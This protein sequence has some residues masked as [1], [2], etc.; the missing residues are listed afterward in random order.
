MKSH[1]LL[2]LGLLVP[3]AADSLAGTLRVRPDGSGDVPT[4]QAAVNAAGSG[5]DVL[6][7]P[8]TYT[9]PGN[10]Y[11]ILQ[12][13]GVTILS[14]QGSEVTIVDCQYLGPGFVIQATGSGT[15]E[16][17]GLTIRNAVM[18]GTGGGA[19]HVNNSRAIIRN[20]ILQSN[21]AEIGGGGVFLLESWGLIENNIIEGNSASAGGGIAVWTGSTATIRKN[22]ICSNGATSRGG[23]VFYLYRAGGELS[24]N[25]IV[26][27]N[28]PVG[29][30]IRFDPNATPVVRANIISFNVNGPG[31]SCEGGTLPSLSCNDVFGNMFGDALC[32]TDI[33]GNFSSDPLFCGEEYFLDS[34]SPCSP[35][36]NSCGILIGARPVGCGAVAVRTVTWGNIKS[37]YEMDK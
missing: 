31:L 28:S 9:G 11:V 34:L 6:L 22:V 5:D 2:I 25:T 16:L 13:K 14:E 12:G 8:G 10:R 7:E 26:G 20:N 15:V 18:Q 30:G 21:R 37:L 32:G 3:M 36:N 4:I 24:N 29:A 35:R 1:Y 19:V 17:D 23:G 33:G 27:N